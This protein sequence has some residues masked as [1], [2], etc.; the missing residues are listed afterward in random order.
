[1]YTE[2]KRTLDEKSEVTYM[3][4]TGKRAEK[5]SLLL[6]A[7]GKSSRMGRD[8]AGLSLEGKLFPRH[9]MDKAQALGIREKFLS[10]HVWE[11][12][13]ARVI[14]DVYKERGPMGGLHA[15]MKAMETPYCLVVPVDVPQLPLETLDAL[16]RT[17][18]ENCL[19]GRGNLPV[20]LVH[21]DRE[22]PL[23]GI[24][25][26]EMADTIGEAI[27]EKSCKVFKVLNQWG[28]EKCEISMEEWQA[29]NINTPEEYA[30]LLKKVSEET[31]R[32]TLTW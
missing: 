28:Y 7:G 10:G 22:E 12:G 15:C 26:T 5:Y 30:G 23:I 13:D 9:L 8:K 27:R 25:P 11:E 17:H 1:M 4:D 24:Y 29:G 31:K 20:L 3:N 14:E 2:Q 6:L 32:G 18:E 19:E 21:G 16:L